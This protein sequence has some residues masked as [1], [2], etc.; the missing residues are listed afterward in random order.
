MV[1]KRQITSKYL[2]QHV[3]ERILRQEEIVYVLPVRIP[4]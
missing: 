1:D 3:M 4:I 2:Y